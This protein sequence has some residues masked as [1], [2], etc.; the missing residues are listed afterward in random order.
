MTTG[1]HQGAKIP[2]PKVA[3]S[4]TQDL[5]GE[6]DERQGRGGR[7]GEGGREGG[8][9]Q[10]G[11]TEGRDKE[12]RKK[13]IEERTAGPRNSLQPQPALFPSLPA[14]HRLLG[15]SGTGRQGSPLT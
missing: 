8:E 13:E 5:P 15:P 9:E 4:K 2:G 11:K 3:A 1:L 7:A 10:A 12:P 14:C 6:G